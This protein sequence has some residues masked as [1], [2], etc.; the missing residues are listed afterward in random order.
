MIDD[1]VI[2]TGNPI[3]GEVGVNNGKRL[4]NEKKTSF[5]LNPQIESS[6]HE[7]VQLAVVRGYY[8]FDI[9]FAPNISTLKKNS[10]MFD[11]FVDE[12]T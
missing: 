8:S 4:I 2:S 9:L 10:N 3:H 5:T 11:Y 6:D 7:K 12:S 1:L